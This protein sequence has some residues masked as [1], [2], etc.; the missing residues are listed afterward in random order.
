MSSQ[1]A[2]KTLIP[3]AFFG[4][5]AFANYTLVTGDVAPPPVE[6]VMKGAFAQE[7]DGIYRSNLPHRDVAVSWVGA[8]RYALLNEGRDG[9]VTGRDGWLFSD[10]EFRDASAGLPLSE[11]IDW[12]A[13]AEA[14]LQAVGS[15]LVVVP[16]PAKLEID[17]ARSGSDDAVGR[18][19]LTYD[20]FL[21]ALGDAGI[22]YVDT[23][24]ALVG[25]DRAFFATDTHWTVQ[26][27]SAVAQTVA[28]SDVIGR[29]QV[30]FVRE[31]QP[32][33]PFTGDL[34]TFVTSDGLA[35]LIGLPEERIIPYKA[36]E[37]ISDNDGALDLFGTDGPAAIALVGTSYSAN[38]RWSFLAALKLSLDTDVVNYA[39]EGQGPIAPMQAFLDSIDP[40]ALPPVVIWE[41]PVRYLSDPALFE[42][43]TTD[44]DEN[45]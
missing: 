42:A 37:T 1:I 35:P 39:T 3:A 14:D 25:L 15:A 31:V 10:E 19:A 2:I 16:L 11:T 18:M 20:E 7:L 13:R 26:G 29:G 21:K 44:G 41:F 17:A 32:E 30:R 12:I 36:V 4:Y 34:V 9:V 28:A 38:P 45:A 23:R 27:A 22:A 33:Q 43:V 24:P 5:T 40:A 6:G 8:A